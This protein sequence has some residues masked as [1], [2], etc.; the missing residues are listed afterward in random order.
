MKPRVRRLS[1][2]NA[3]WLILAAGLLTAGHLHGGPI[4]D[5][6]VTSVGSSPGGTPIYRFTYFLS[7]ISLLTNEELAIQ[8]DPALYGSLSNGSGPAGIDIALFQ[9]NNPLGATGVYSA[10]SLID[11]PSLATPFRVDAIY[12]GAGSPG[13]QLFDI[14]QYD[15]A[16]GFRV[17]DSGTTQVV[18]GQ[19][20]P[21]PAPFASVGA[22]LGVLA[23]ACAWVRRRSRR[24]GQ[25]RALLSGS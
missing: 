21:E 9:P 6:Q 14:N 19:Q 8:F 16:G 23:L 17:V 10:L 4:L 15:D 12:L 5:Y 18:G 20:V 25:L 2:L 24:S 22:M 1:D 7:G 3:V 13:P 11:N